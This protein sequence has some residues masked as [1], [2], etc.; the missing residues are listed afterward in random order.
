MKKFVRTMILTVCLALS[1]W[2]LA[3][4]GAQKTSV[5]APV[6]ASKVYTGQVQ[7][8]TVAESDAYTVTTNDG[9]TDVGE[10]TVV[11]TLTD[12]AKY[13]WATPD[14]DD[15]TRLTLKFTITKADNAITALSVG[16][17]AYGSEI[18]P[19]ASAT[20]GSVTFTY[21][22]A[23]DG[24]Y[25]AAKPTALGD[26]FVKAS[27]E[28]TA[29][30]A[31]AEKIEQFSIVKADSAIT[32]DPAPVADLYA[33]NTEKTLVT[34]GEATGGTLVYALV[35]GE[36]ATP[37]ESLADP[38]AW[39]VS[40]PKATAAGKYTVY[41]MVK[42]D[43]N[44][45][46]GELKKV[47]AE[48]K[49]NANAITGLSSENVVY[50]GAAPAPTA[51]ATHGTITYTY[52]LTEDGEYVSWE[53][54][55]KRAGTY[56]VK[57]T[58]AEDET[59]LGATAT[60]SFTMNKAANVLSVV[61]NEIHC[62]ENPDLTTT[63]TDSASAVTYKYSTTADGE[64]SEI[65]EFTAGTYYVKA[66]AAESDNY[67]AGESAPVSF[68]VTHNH[69]WTEGETV[70]EKK[71]ACGDVSET[72][73]KT[74]TSLDAQRTVLGVANDGT[75]SDGT[76][77]ISLDG[78]SEYAS[79]ESAKL[80]E[81]TIA[82]TKGDGK[83]VSLRLSDF[84]YAYGE[85]TISVIVKDSDGASHAIPVKVL[86]VTKVITDKDGLNAFGTIAKKCE[87]ADNAWGGY[88]E[89]GSD[90]V[91]NDKW[92]SFIDAT[93]LDNE[94]KTVGDNDAI[95]KM[96]GFVGTFDG[97]GFD[98][99]G[100]RVVYGSAT[101]AGGFI[102]RLGKDGVI[103]NV[104]FS[105]ACVGHERTFLSYSVAG[106]IEDVYIGYAVFGSDAD[107][108]YSTAHHWGSTA[109][110]AK[111]GEEATAVIKNVIVDFTV[112]GKLFTKVDG[113]L[114]GRVNNKNTLSE[115]YFVGVPSD[116][117]TN[118]ATEGSTK[119][120]VVTGVSVD[121]K[122][123]GSYA[124]MVAANNDYSSFTSSLWTVGEG[125]MPYCAA[126][127][128]KAPTFTTVPSE[129]TKGGSAT[130]VV[131]ENVVLTLDQAAIDA[132]I[133]ISGGL[134]SVPESTEN[135]TYTVIA[136]SIFNKSFT[137][138][139]TF[140]VVNARVTES[141][142]A[143][144]EIDLDV[145]NAAVVNSSKTVTLDLTEKF[146]GTATASAIKV[147]DT[148]IDGLANTAITGG[149]ITLNVSAFGLTYYGNKNVS[150][151]FEAD[152]TEYELTVPV[153]FITKTI[154]G[155]DANLRAIQT[156][157]NA[158]NGGGYYRLGGNI[159]I[160]W[161]WYSS[162]EDHRIG[163]DKPF[164]GTIDGNGYAIDG[165]K[166]MNNTAAS[167]MHELG[168]DGVIKNVAFTGI[169][170]SGEGR[171]IRTIKGTLENV[172]I[173]F[174]SLSSY[175]S[176]V[177]LIEFQNSAKLKNFVLDVSAIAEKYSAQTVDATKYHAL[178]SIAQNANPE[179]NNMY[180]KGV[181]TNFKDNV[182][183]LRDQTPG[184]NG[185]NGAASGIYVGYT[186]NTDN[187]VAFPSTGWDSTYWTVNAETNTVTWNT[188]A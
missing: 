36:E 34:A 128:V 54:V 51:S 149:K 69:V 175:W 107:G 156:I 92:I 63:A 46:D 43:E 49:K 114:L 28:G 88:F 163:V 164:V 8:A 38:S 153:L 56:Y 176:G 7:T 178:V 77:T 11:L 98:I 146:G 180:V 12:S 33:D 13:E 58:V 140:K 168:A 155:G 25:T 183:R 135:G 141:L 76:S 112:A 131:S 118:D 40:L 117:I 5:E 61:A 121:V 95:H 89:L 186:D 62:S 4:C 165:L 111:D 132:G 104:S 24:E 19:T 160:K 20:F 90:I 48:I 159:A 27:V 157:S 29:N 81:T 18:N 110:I 106:T 64:Y 145:T 124:D 167:F 94:D 172:N 31:A 166:I 173:A 120:I 139:A 142:S 134:V 102:T 35:A 66:Y 96:K 59:H 17:V 97:K 184:N 113:R 75:L 93:K 154:T 74:L 16:N 91:Y 182:V 42:G 1:A 137:T 72:F 99:S 73:V 162:S 185:T 105:K 161:D 79:V 85:Q 123:Y 138:S 119:H 116:Y 53:N 83:T 15:A 45:N 37:S 108:N 67:L 170:T 39:S 6:I 144:Q 78:V 122:V 68:N 21:S 26:Y 52:S 174:G 181:A 47:V 152:G 169:T 126:M 57:A 22:T 65:T 136:T 147:G 125:G 23:R 109:T 86:L 133:E 148:I 179:L 10:Y 150:V 70:D 171:F 103:R 9:G 32:T 3:A 84:G 44:H 2:A 129:I 71:C 41:Y 100:L 187:G 14:A 143:T 188:K 101:S 177:Y 130:F 151:V 30:Y 50:N 60:A 158:I 127:G 87:T 115:V 82:A 80:G 55:A